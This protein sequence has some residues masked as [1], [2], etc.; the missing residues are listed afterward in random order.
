MAVVTVVDL[1]SLRPTAA[2][3]ELVAAELIEVGSATAAELVADL[4]LPL[5]TVAA[6]L[7]R[8]ER[9]G[10][11]C[12]TPDGWVPATPR[13]RGPRRSWSQGGKPAS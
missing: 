6:V 2:D 10:R 3:L 13:Q 8:L 9:D 7:R 12:R 1:A 4:G 5:P 11:V